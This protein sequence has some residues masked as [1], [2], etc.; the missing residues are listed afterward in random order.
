MPRLA[1]VVM[2]AGIGSRYGG[3]KQVDPVGPNDELVIDYSV[4]DALRAG[5]DH[6]VFVI[7]RDIE[8]VF[9]EKVGAKVEAR[10]RTS[11]IFQELSQL[12]PGFT[13]P[14]GREKPWGTAQA[15]LICR[16]AVRT[17]FAAI[18]ADDFYGASA[19]K[20]VAGFLTR[21][22]DAGTRQEFAMVGYRLQNTLSEHGSVARGVCEAAEDGCLD[23]IRERLHIERSAD[24]INYTENGKDR[25][26]LSPDKY[27]SMN[28][29]GFTTGL[30]GELALRFRR[31]LRERQADI[32]KAEFLIPEVVGALVREKKV[33]VRILPTEERWFGMTYPEDKPL[34]QAAVRRMIKDGIYPHSLW[35]E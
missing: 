17:A 5:F 14:P 9:R 21:P 2:A 6:I 25:V 18:N 24:G 13:I 23:D 34:V 33:R 28:F 27:V 10:V 19:Y 31:F 11:Y 22:P 12:P 32:L 29:W 4:Y 16:D 35:R 15:I 7:R 30:F 26:A 20:A 8:D 3:L 1:L